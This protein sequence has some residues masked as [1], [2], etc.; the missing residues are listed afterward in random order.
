MSGPR[1]SFRIETEKLT[2]PR[3]TNRGRVA[4]EPSDGEYVPG[5]DLAGRRYS[6]KRRRGPRR[7]GQARIRHAKSVRQSHR[8]AQ[9]VALRAGTSR[10]PDQL[11]LLARLRAF[12]SPLHVQLMGQLY[13][14]A[15]D[16]RAVV[17]DCHLADERPV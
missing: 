12:R 1:Q 15:H 3:C 8:P 9:Q 2:A 5:S 17:P 10:L 11:Q 13:D 14:R 4:A 16:G 6:I 7:L